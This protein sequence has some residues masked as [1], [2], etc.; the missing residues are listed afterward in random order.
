MTPMLPPNARVVHVVIEVMGK[1]ETDVSRLIVPEVSVGPPRAS[2]IDRNQAELHP[3][4]GKGFPQ[5]HHQV[6][7]ALDQRIAVDLDPQAI[8]DRIQHDLAAQPLGQRMLD[9]PD[10]GGGVDV[11]KL[12]L[13]AQVACVR[14]HGLVQPGAE[15]L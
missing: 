15:R 9:H 3:G 12:S 7:D 2:E 6:R 14:T 8:V 11:F 13:G 1:T 10:R 4:N 5:L